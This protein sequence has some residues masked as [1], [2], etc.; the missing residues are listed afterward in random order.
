EKFEQ[1]DF[2]E[3]RV[4]QSRA[5]Q[6]VHDAFSR[7]TDLE[8][9]VGL[10]AYNPPA[11]ADVVEER[12]MIDSTTLV[13][14]DAAPLALAAME[15]GQIDALL[16]QDP[17]VMGYLGIKE[18]KALVDTDDKALHEISPQFGSGDNGEIHEPGLKIVVPEGSQ[19]KAELF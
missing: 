8:L 4:D 13:G 10:W 7:T 18:L 3:D 16:V 6:N 17:Y 19:L 11:I 9:L 12:G 2:L 15:K 5:R 1:V 14:F